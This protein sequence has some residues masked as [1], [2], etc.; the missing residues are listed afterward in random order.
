M[1]D[2]LIPYEQKYI[3]WIHKYASGKY[4]IASFP[5]AEKDFEHCWSEMLWA[6]FVEAKNALIEKYNAEQ[7]ATRPTRPTKQVIVMR[8][9]LKMRRGKEIAQ[10]SHAAMSFLT[11]NTNT[12]DAWELGDMWTELVI[13]DVDYQILEWLESSYRKI[14][15]SVNSEEELVDIYNKAKEAK[16]EVYLIEDNGL[17]EFAGVKTKTCLAIGPDYDERIDPITKHLPLY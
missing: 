10:G 7:W 5:D 17:T 4:A 14:C 1:D 6:N 12:Q 15:C 3:G 13:H 2:F 9:D 11:R 16:L 8:K